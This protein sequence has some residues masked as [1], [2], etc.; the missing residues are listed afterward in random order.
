MKKFLLLCSVPALFF[1][2]NRAKREQMLKGSWQAVRVLEADSLLPV[3]DSVI[4]LHFYEDHSYRYEGT[5]NYRESGHWR[6]QNH[7]LITQSRD[8]TAKERQVRIQKLSSDSLFLEMQ[9][10]GRKRLLVMRKLHE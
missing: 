6:L 7:L 2:C 9:E 1:A 5:L 10:K 3:P 4:Q 8:K